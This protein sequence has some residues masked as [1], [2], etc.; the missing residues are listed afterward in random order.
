MAD[1]Y[2]Y[3]C[4][5]CAGAACGKT[6]D[7][8]DGEPCEICADAVC[9]PIRVLSNAGVTK[10]L[11]P[12]YEVSADSGGNFSSKL[13]NEQGI[14]LEDPAVREFTRE[15]RMDDTLYTD[16]EL[17]AWERRNDA[18]KVVAECIAFCSLCWSRTR[19]GERVD[20]D[21]ARALKINNDHI[22]RQQVF[23]SI[24]DDAAAAAAEAEAETEEEGDLQPSKKTRV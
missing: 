8:H 17:E 18:A 16:E 13:L 10:P 6:S 1:G 5:A 2:F 3:T 11:L 7:E 15:K 21:A 9:V 4:A 20:H 14:V 23:A 22:I 19:A 24:K 12:F